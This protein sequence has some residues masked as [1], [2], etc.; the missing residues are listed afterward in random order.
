[1]AATVRQ[2]VEWGERPDRGQVAITAVR[3]EHSREVAVSK[4]VKGRGRWGWGEGPIEGLQKRHNF[5]TWWNV[6]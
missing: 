2:A 6:L 5:I 3:R 1:M 4:H